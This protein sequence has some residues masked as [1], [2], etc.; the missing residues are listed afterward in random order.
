CLFRA[1]QG[2]R[3]PR[4]GGE[5]HCSSQF[6]LPSRASGFNNATVQPGC[7]KIVLG[8]DE[9]KEARGTGRRR[10][11]QIA[12]LPGEAA[13]GPSPPLCEST[14]FPDMDRA[15]L[16]TTTGNFLALPARNEWGEG[17]PV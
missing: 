16:D 1:N 10:P 12:R 4:C 3:R 9:F 8:R 13:T 15:H 5:H 11:R 6:H 7:A 14:L 17:R 2:P